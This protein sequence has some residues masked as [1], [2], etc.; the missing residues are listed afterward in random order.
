MFAAIARTGSLAQASA[1][2]G[3]STATLSRR[4]TALEAQLGR[5]LFRHGS[6]GYALTEDGI[7]L[8]ARAEE[9]EA[10]AAR[11]TEW[12]SRDT[13]PRRIRISAGTWTAHAL[14]QDVTRYWNA[15]AIWVPEFLYCDLEMDIA[16]REIDIG[17]RNKRPDQPWL[18]GQKTAEIT[19]AIYG[20]PDAR[21]FIGT[22]DDAAQTPS[23][24]WLARHHGD[25]IVTRV[26]DPRLGLAFAEAGMGRI[27]LPC[28][29][30]D[31]TGLPRHGDIIEDL[32]HEEWLVSHHEGRHHPPVR[33][34]LTAIAEYLS[35][36]LRT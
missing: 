21:G 34:A 2:L 31:Q 25:A 19:F 3:V 10:A 22:A 32:T 14:A 6:E 26:N 28:F 13:G 12:Q 5:R 11:I 4:M 27:V 17:I 33:A 1:T 29:I 35:N 20:Q 8:M 15:D 16:R 36:R 9:M 23:A 7:D 30:G 24:R 18:A